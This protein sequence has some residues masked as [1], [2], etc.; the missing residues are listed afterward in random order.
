MIM[1]KEKEATD[2][3]KS[4]R[5]IVEMEIEEVKKKYSKYE[6]GKNEYGWTWDI[7]YF[8]NFYCHFSLGCYR[9][10]RDKILDEVC[11]GQYMGKSTREFHADVDRLIEETGISKEE[12]DRLQNEIY[13]KKDKSENY[14]EPYEKLMEVTLPVFIGLRAMGYTYRDLIG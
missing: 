6:G 8:N 3:E 12:I 1:T 7:K 10:M 2:K 9:N 4:M 14:I 5:K 13:E 11:E